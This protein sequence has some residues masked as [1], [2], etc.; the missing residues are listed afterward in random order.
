MSHIFLHF[1]GDSSN[2]IDLRGGNKKKSV[3]K[4]LEEYITK[5]L[6]SKKKNPLKPIKPRQPKIYKYRY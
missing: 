2:I 6:K 5:N 1:L 3:K 4:S